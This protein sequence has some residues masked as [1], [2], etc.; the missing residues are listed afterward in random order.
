MNQGQARPSDMGRCPSLLSTY[1][2]PEERG[3]TRPVCLAQLRDRQL[4]ATSFAIASLTTSLAS[5]QMSLSLIG[6]SRT[7]SGGIPLPAAT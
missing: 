1:S 5:A 3:G 2:M 6:A 4:A 7:P